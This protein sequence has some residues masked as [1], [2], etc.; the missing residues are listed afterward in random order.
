MLVA[1]ACGVVSTPG[2]AALVSVLC[3]LMGRATGRAE[4]TNGPVERYV[5]AVSRIKSFDVTMRVY[6]LSFPDMNKL[7]KPNFPAMASTN[8]VRDVFAPGLGR[9]VERYVGRAGGEVNQISVMEW[10]V[11]AGSGN[12]SRALHCGLAGRDYL[13]YLNPTEDKFFLTDLLR[14]RGS[15][16]TPLDASLSPAEL[17]GFEVKHPGLNGAIR[18]WLDSRHGWM[19]KKVEVYNVG[20][21][22]GK[23][24]LSTLIQVD[25]FIQ[26]EGDVWA[27]SKGSLNYIVHAGPAVG[28]AHYGCTIAIDAERSFWNTIK[29]KELF[30]AASLPAFNHEERG[31][32]QYY[33]EAILQAIKRADKIRTGN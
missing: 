9:R 12:L 30:V 19:L 23:K 3:C 26:V 11:A 27:P 22:S 28:R 29:S 7:E 13:G 14:D 33:P 16:I 17:A 32:K 5:S 15:T 10:D 24:R 31:W 6:G 18:F 21:R 25:E 4:G 8:T 20:E 2:V 1:T